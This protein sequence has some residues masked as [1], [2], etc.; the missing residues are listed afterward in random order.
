VNT[1]AGYVQCPHCAV[2]DSDPRWC[3]LCGKSKEIGQTANGRAADR[4]KRWTSVL[5]PN[6]SGLTVDGRSSA[7][8]RR[9]K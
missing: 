5:S 3:V 7:R 9:L 8:R 1:Y 4:E 6:E 2:Y